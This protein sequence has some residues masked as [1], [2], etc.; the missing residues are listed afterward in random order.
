MS[1]EIPAD[2]P[3]AP[4]DSPSP[5]G[6]EPSAELLAVFTSPALF[7]RLEKFARKKKVPARATQDVVQD[8]LAT[9]WKGRRRWPREPQALVPWMYTVTHARAVDWFRAQENTE[10][11]LGKKDTIVARAAPAAPMEAYEALQWAREHAATKPGLLRAFGWVTRHVMGE[12]YVEIAEK[13]GV[14]E[15]TVR[16]AVFDLRQSLVEHLGKDT[17][18]AVLGA[19]LVLLA[20]SLIWRARI[21]AHRPRPTPDLP[22]IE[23][24]APAPAP[25]PAPVAPS[26]PKELTAQELRDRGVQACA[27]ERWQDCSADLENAAQLDPVGA[28]DPK[29]KALRERARYMAIGKP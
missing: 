7:K 5:E 18:L 8:A 28:K 25:A 17:V 27:E 9:A 6:I 2:L 21:E 4:G 20:V 14:T 29:M 19:F 11:H 3:S 10:Q 23:Q 22:R 12:S 15:E 26:P 24:P 13:D 1:T 16:S